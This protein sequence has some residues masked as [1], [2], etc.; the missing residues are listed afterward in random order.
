MTVPNR[1]SKRTAEVKGPIRCHKCQL[2]CQDA[3]QYLS[4]TCKS[5]G[6]SITAQRLSQ[7]EA[8]LVG[9]AR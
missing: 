1:K 6:L 5:A 4:H 8:V 7:G 9:N 2:K 3:K